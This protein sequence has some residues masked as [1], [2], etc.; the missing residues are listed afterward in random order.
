MSPSRRAVI[1]A[2]LT[3]VTTLWSGCG[4]RAEDSCERTP[5]QSPVEAR[6]VGPDAERTLFDRAAVTRVGS[7]RAHQGAT[8][9]DVELSE[10]TRADVREHFRSLDVVDRPDRFEVAVVEADRVVARFR[11]QHS[12]VDRVASGDWNGTVR[13]TFEDNS[14]AKSLHE[15]FRCG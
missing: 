7:V 6:L 3:A 8:V 1:G 11:V 5:A 13:L 9:F 2:A 14:T 10:P 15:R 4:S 12:L